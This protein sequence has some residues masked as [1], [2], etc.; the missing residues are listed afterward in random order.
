MWRGSKIFDL[1]HVSHIGRPRTKKLAKE[2]FCTPNEG[3]IGSWIQL[4][5]WDAVIIYHDARRPTNR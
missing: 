5:A 3:V 2:P 1:L 4:T